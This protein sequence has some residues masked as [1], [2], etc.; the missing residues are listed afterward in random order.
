MLARLDIS[1]LGPIGQALTPRINEGEALRFTIRTLNADLAVVVPTSLR[2]RIDGAGYSDPLVNWTTL[3]PAL[4]V[5][6]IITG[7]QNA[8]TYDWGIGERTVLVEAGD[9][10]GVIRKTFHYEIADLLGVE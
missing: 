6:V 5:N 10:E 3:T 9:A 2:Y 1:V 7:A 8:R 4:A